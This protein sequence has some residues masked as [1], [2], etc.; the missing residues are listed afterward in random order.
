MQLGLAAVELRGGLVDGNLE[1]RR[2]DGSAN[3][4]RLD[5]RI[6]VAREGLYRAG[7]IGADLHRGAR[8]DRAGDIDRALHIALRH[9]GSHI[10]RLGVRLV[11]PIVPA[12]DCQRDARDKQPKDGLFQ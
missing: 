12:G 7:N 9:L 11:P 4:A 10:A 8:V 6:E 2:I 3:L 5:L 1:G